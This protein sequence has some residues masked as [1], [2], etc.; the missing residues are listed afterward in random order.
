MEASSKRRSLDDNVSLVANVTTILSGLGGGL[1]IFS[2]IGA[3]PRGGPMRALVVGWRTYFF[4]KT[5]PLSVRVN[6]INRLLNDTQTLV[7]GSYI[8]V[9]GGK[10]FGKSRLI[11]TAL[12]GQCGVVKM[13]TK[14]GADKDLIVD[15]ALRELTAIRVNYFSPAGSARRVLWFYS[16]MFFWCPPPIVV[17]RVPERQIGQ[18]YA[19]VTSA[20]RSLADDF[21]LRV[22]VDGS[23]NS[24]PPE[25]LATTRETTISVEPMAKDQIESISEL[26]DLIDFLKT[27]Q[28]DYPVWKVLGGSPANYLKL[29]EKFN[30]LKLT[31]TATD[32]I[33]EEVKNHLQSVLLDALNKNVGKSSSNTKEIIK[34]FRDKKAIKIPQME[35]EAMG[36]LVDYPN[37]VFRE[38]KSL[39]DWFVEP[40]TSAVSLIISEN[41]Q[42]GAGVHELREKLLKE[43]PETTK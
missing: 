37:K 9:T 28:L 6:E 41:V 1:A 13:S 34:V 32:L 35:L 20:V 10:G 36:F 26:K 29:K 4:N 25:L 8:T 39:E 18:P 19:D 21:G 42:N 30:G 7:R 16:F 12:N 43:A 22:I 31:H 33:V 17:I 27:H 2:A 11:D 15:Q 23:P 40:A 38:V 5:S 3:I 14:S 24:L